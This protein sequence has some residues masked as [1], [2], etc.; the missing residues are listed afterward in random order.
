MMPT[1]I[2]TVSFEVVLPIG[3]MPKTERGH[4]FCYKLLGNTSTMP[5]ICYKKM[6]RVSLLLNWICFSLL[7]KKLQISFEPNMLS[8]IAVMTYNKMTL[9]INARVDRVLAIIS[10][11]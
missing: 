10:N 4:L 11:G 9:L 3:A 5:K 1:F 7:E 2:Y 8:K 6:A